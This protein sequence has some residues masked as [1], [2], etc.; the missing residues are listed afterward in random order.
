MK[1]V[2]FCN[3]FCATLLLFS[4]DINAFSKFPLSESLQQNVNNLFI[5]NWIELQRTMNDCICN[6][7]SLNSTRV[8]NMH[9]EDLSP[10][11]QQY[12]Q[13]LGFKSCSGPAL[14]VLIK[15]NSQSA[16]INEFN[17]KVEAFNNKVKKK[18]DSID[19]K[20]SH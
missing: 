11:D 5:K 2:R 8:H 14:Y 6:C 13:F 4:N 1:F 20:L 15:L 10:S 12:L 7:G 9:Y 16:N 17:N 18:L 3:V 19:K